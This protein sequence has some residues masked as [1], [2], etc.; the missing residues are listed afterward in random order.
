MSKPKKDRIGTPTDE[1]PEIDFRKAMVVRRGPAVGRLTTLS[2]LR[3]SAGMTQTQLA[4]RAKMSQ[5]ELSRVEH[6]RD[7]LVSTLERYANALNGEL[8]V[9]VKIDGRSY[10][11]SLAS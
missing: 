4:R 10:P 3:A 7:C 9:V 1:M 2:T 6:Q 11:I 5:G 8:E